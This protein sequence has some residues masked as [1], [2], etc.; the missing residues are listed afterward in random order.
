MTAGQAGRRPAGQALQAGGRQGKAGQ[1]GQAG[2]CN[3]FQHV[4]IKVFKTT[5]FDVIPEAILAPPPPPIE[6]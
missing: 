6:S 4:K 5:Y 3:G 1:T 2:K